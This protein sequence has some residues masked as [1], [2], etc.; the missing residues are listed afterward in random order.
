MRDRAPPRSKSRARFGANL[1]RKPPTQLE[2][3]GHLFQLRANA[4]RYRE[5]GRLH[6]EDDR[7]NVLDASTQ[8][9]RNLLSSGREIPYRPGYHVTLETSKE[10]GVTMVR[11]N[12]SNPCHRHA[13]L[14]DYHRGDRGTAEYGRRSCPN[15]AASKRPFA[16]PGKP[17][18]RGVMSTPLERK[19]LRYLFLYRPISGIRGNALTGIPS[20]IDQAQQRPPLAGM[21]PTDSWTLSER[22]AE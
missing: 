4:N 8:R 6:I 5:K 13:G 22:T 9:R 20:S 21:P 2:A 15:D 17:L 7:S 11:G 16:A 12:S 19:Y 10:S 3:R 1:F 18:A 14:W